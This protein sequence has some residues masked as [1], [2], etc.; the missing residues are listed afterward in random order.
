MVGAAQ[1]DAE[2]NADRARM[3][4]M[5]LVRLVRYADNVRP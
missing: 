4:R 5:S 1:R 2:S 3:M